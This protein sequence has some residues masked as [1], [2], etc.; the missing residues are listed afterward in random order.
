MV[1]D[2]LLMSKIAEGVSRDMPLRDTLAWYCMESGDVN[3]KELP[4]DDQKCRK[5]IEGAVDM[6]FKLKGLEYVDPD[7]RP[8]PGREVSKIMNY[9]GFFP[10]KEAFALTLGGNP[11]SC[12]PGIELSIDDNIAA[13]SVKR[14]MDAYFVMKKLPVRD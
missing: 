14:M 8:F 2:Y 7:P 10:L 4:I 1:N 11:L 13:L 6:H 9:V 5:V 12:Q 3:F